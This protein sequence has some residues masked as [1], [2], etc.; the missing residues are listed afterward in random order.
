MNYLCQF[1]Y[2][3]TLPSEDAVAYALE[4]A[5]H[6]NYEIPSKPFPDELREHVENWSFEV[7]EDMEPNTIAIFSE[8]GGLDAAMEFTKHLLAKFNQPDTVTFCWGCYG[9]RPA[10][11]AASGGS[12]IITAS[13]VETQNS[14]EW[15]AAAAKRKAVAV[16]H[17]ALSEALED[18]ERDNDSIRDAAI[19]L[20][21]A[22]NSTCGKG[23]AMI[24]K[25]QKTST[26]PT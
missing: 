8:D 16:A 7:E 1:C 24:A 5:H 4:L 22:L 25:N 20:C 10:T 18:T 6:G 15:L 14:H 9:D 13:S 26:A 2:K 23:R 19:R 21:Q 12:A 17:D 11:D 3:L